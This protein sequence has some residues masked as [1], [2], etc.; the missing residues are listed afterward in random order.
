M[1]GADVAVQTLAEPDVKLALPPETMLIA[2]EMPTTASTAANTAK[3]LDRR[4]RAVTVNLDVPDAGAPAG[5]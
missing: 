3:N 4:R 2:T 5:P 1:A